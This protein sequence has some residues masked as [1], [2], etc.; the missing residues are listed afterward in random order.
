M[1]NTLAL[2]QTGG[3]GK[4]GLFILIAV[5][6]VVIVFFAVVMFLASRYR[7]CPS[8]RILVIWGTNAVSTQVNVMTHAIR[9]RK[10]RGAK[11]V[12]I[13]IYDTPTM[14]Q[15]DIRI[16]LKPGTDGAFACAVMHVLFRDGFADREYMAK[17]TDVPDEL[18]AHLRSRTPEWAAAI[19]GLSVEEIES[20]A[21]AYGETERAYIRVGYGFT[22]SR[23]GS[24]NMHAVSCLPAVGGKWKTEGGGAHQNQVA[25]S[26]EKQAADIGCGYLLLCGR[27]STVHGQ[28]D[29]EGR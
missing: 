7:R 16:L 22:R 2:S 20:F 18:E 26:V 25:L 14:K 29:A 9:A 27:R 6:I 15:A 17:Y 8:N 5:V 12:V 11:I 21:R 23:N 13:D 4:Q 24:A 1:H 3:S 28:S 10:E 19:T